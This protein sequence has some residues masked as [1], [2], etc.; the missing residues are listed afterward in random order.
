[1]LICN[2]LVLKKADAFTT[3]LA[4]VALLPNRSVAAFIIKTPN[5]VLVWPANGQSER[6]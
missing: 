6:K 2:Q 4:D 5:A 1:M 3:R